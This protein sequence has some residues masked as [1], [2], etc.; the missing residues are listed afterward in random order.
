ML[1]GLLAVGVFCICLLSGDHYLDKKTRE[2]RF[3]EGCKAFEGVPIQSDI[4]Q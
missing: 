1:E 2:C 3:K 4:P